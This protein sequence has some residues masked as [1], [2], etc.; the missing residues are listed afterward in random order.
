MRFS[1]TNMVLIEE[2]TIETEGQGPIMQ[3]PPQGLPIQACMI[4]CLFNCGSN[5]FLFSG[6]N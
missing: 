2:R 6:D 3:A 5:I 1:F 4:V